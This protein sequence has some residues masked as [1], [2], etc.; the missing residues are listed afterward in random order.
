MSMPPVTERR[1]VLAIVGGLAVVMLGIVVV[2]PRWH[3]PQEP[4]STREPS[5]SQTAG[6]ESGAT[7][8]PGSATPRA[9][10]GT[11]PSAPPVG[12]AGTAGPGSGSASEPGD[13]TGPTGSTGSTGPANPADPNGPDTTAGTPDD[14]SPFGSGPTWGAG[15]GSSPGSGSGGR[16][17]GRPTRPPGSAQ[18]SPPAVVDELPEPVSAVDRLVPGFPDVL[19]PPSGSQVKVSGL[20]TEGDHAEV[21]LV[22]STS[23]PPAAVVGHYRER[24][25]EIGFAQTQEVEAGAESTAVFARGPESVVVTASVGSFSLLASVVPDPVAPRGDTGGGSPAQTG[26]ASPDVADRAQVPTAEPSPSAPPSSTPPAPSST[27]AP[28]APTDP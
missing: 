9:G 8:A 19:A 25:G 21:S 17:G 12:T 28:P 26:T 18:G 4:A 3:S 5:A 7:S 20:S 10:R 24:L 2:V 13:P 16:G 22:A 15:T 14:S 1:L 23:E 6:P 27:P 11:A